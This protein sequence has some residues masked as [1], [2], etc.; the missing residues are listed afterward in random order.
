MKT[1]FLR[2]F[3]WF[4]AANAILIAA[5]VIGYGVTNPDQLPFAW[6]RVGK[7]AVISAG[8]VAAQA[9]E[10][11]GQKELGRF[12]KSLAQDP[13]LEG[14]RFDSSERDLSGGAPN[15]QIPPELWS[16]P[17]GQLLLHAPKR[18]AAIRITTDTG[19]SY[20]FVTRVPRREPT[21]FWS[22]M[23]IAAF[24]ATGALLC[25]LLAR[26]I[27]MPVVQL[28]TLAARFSGGDFS[29]RMT[30]QTVLG[31]KDEIGGLARDFNRMHR[32]LNYS[33]T[34]NTG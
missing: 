2:M 30:L 10:Q 5:I 28:R 9:Y 16:R 6:P 21:G 8:H 4:C 3:L 26:N 1:L 24:I 33:S 25:Y 27:T 29:A 17:A 32:A 7:G 12:L 34:H 14:A 20:T 22:R 31:R 23:F 15:I 13:G 19:R 11:G 18:L